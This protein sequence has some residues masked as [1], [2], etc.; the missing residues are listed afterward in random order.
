M[1]EIINEKAITMVD[2]QDALKKIEGREKDKEL[3]FRAKKA[4]E[5]L[6]MFVCVK[7]AEAEKLR[8]EL[9][10]LSIARLKERHIAKIIDIMP[11]DIEGL[12]IMLS[13]ETISPK[14]EDLKKIMDVLKEYHKK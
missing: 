9:E 8:K 5:Y 14:S 7:K 4:K 11:K 13:G 10:G 3:N 1:M 6:K 12:K 2:A